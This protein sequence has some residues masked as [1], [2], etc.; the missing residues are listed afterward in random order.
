MVAHNQGVC[1][2]R[3]ADVSEPQ[4]A[5]HLLLVGNV[6]RVN[7]RLAEVGKDVTENHLQDSPIVVCGH[8]LRTSRPPPF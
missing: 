6:E 4:S 3:I 7:A 5:G 2:G 1:A 8:H